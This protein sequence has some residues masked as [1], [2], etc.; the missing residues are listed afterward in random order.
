MMGHPVRMSGP[1]IAAALKAG[2]RE[3]FREL[4][5]IFLKAAPTSEEVAEVARR[6]PDRYVQGVTMLA[7]LS[8]FHEKMQVDH[9]HTH[10][11]MAL[12]QLSDSELMGRLQDGLEQLGIVPQA[13]KLLL[14]GKQGVPESSKKGN[15][16]K[17]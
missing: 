6:A 3:P 16:A 15:G 12:M 9:N 11:V 1:E 5:E 14:A 8:G 13:F 17:S 2:S 7:K 4:L 10:K